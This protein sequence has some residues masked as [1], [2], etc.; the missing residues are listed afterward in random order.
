METTYRQ[1]GNERSGRVFVIAAI[2]LVALAGAYFGLGMPGMDHSGDVMADMDHISELQALSPRMFEARMAE[3]GAFV[4]DVHV[5]AG[6]TI[7]GTDEL[8]AFDAIV[9]S[10]RLPADKATP[11]LLYCESG[12]MSETAGRAVLRAGYIDVGHLSGGLEAWRR[13]DLPLTSEPLLAR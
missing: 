1:Q 6:E 4:V 8:I 12:R 11:I 5:P 9:D 13:A 7:D 3:G 2:A 10:G